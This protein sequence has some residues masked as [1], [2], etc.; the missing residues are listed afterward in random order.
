MAIKIHAL[1]RVRSSNGSADVNLSSFVKA[2]M[3]SFK[4]DEEKP[5]SGKKK[6][7]ELL[8]KSDNRICADCSAP[9]PKWASANIGVF[10]CLKCS[11]VHRS[12]GT[13]ISKTDDEIDAM[14][15]VGGNSY[16]NAI[17]EAFLPQGC[18]KPN[19]DSS[20]EERASFIRNSSNQVYGSFLRKALSSLAI[21]EKSAAL[22]RTAGMVEFIGILKVK[23]I[24]GTNLAIRDML[25][26]D[27]YVVL[28]I[29]QQ[30]SEEEKEDRKVGRQITDMFRPLEKDLAVA[31][32]LR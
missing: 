12:L 17:Y 18:S 13:H 27:P 23:V 2:K 14:V 9:D 32:G 10:I 8:L 19:P 16:A 5:S 20:H 30:L 7:K 3:S 11:G 25:S 6:L 22:A 21:L 31:G 1:C 29:G 28:T 24:K 26:S 4:Y 15:E